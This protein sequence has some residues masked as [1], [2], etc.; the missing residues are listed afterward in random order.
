M[1]KCVGYQF[2]VGTFEDDKGRSVAYDN[3]CLYYTSNNNPEVVG[4][5]AGML[6]IKRHQ[7]SAVSAVPPQDLV[8]HEMHVEYQPVG[9]K[10]VITKIAVLK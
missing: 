10:L 9:G 4:V 2:K 6:K 8:G 5:E 3:V 7:F 1:I